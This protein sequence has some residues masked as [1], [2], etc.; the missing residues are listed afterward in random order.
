[1][2]GFKSVSTNDLLRK[3]NFWVSLS[4]VIVLFRSKD[5][6]AYHRKLFSLGDDD[7]GRFGILPRHDHHFAAVSSDDLDLEQDVDVSGVMVK[8]RRNMIMI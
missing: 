3:N 1:M 6:L 8:H 4:F 2:C 5:C 7:L